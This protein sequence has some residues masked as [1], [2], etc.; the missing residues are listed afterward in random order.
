M[1]NQNIGQNMN[2]QNIPDILSKLAERTIS[3]IRNDLG[4]ISTMTMKLKM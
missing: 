3:Y 1:N 4:M 2:N